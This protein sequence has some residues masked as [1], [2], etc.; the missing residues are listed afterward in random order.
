MSWLTRY[1]IR[2]YVRSSLFLAP[3]ASIALALPAGAQ[4][5][6]QFSDEQLDQ[7]T[8]P[9]ALYPDSLLAQLLMA[10]TYPDDFAAAAA[11]W[12]RQ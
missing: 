9:I 4:D 7:L 12:P 1:R 2:K 6:R 10:T 11:W 3:T 5:A 8:A